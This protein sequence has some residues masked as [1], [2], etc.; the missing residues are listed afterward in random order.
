MSFVLYNSY[1]GENQVG[2]LIDVPNRE[3]G[4]TNDIR[5][6]ADEL[7][8]IFPRMTSIDAHGGLRYI[9]D[10]VLNKMFKKYEPLGKVAVVQRYVPMQ[11]GTSRA[12]A[13]PYAANLSSPKRLR[14]NFMEEVF[15]RT[16]G[17]VC[18]KSC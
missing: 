9:S 2:D 5:Y 8:T 13:T 14:E 10:S 6:F 3:G 16:P 1:R 17:F 11:S 7:R 4:Y 15:G 12:G 18:A